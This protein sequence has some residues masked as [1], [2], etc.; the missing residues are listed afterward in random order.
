MRVLMLGWEFPP[1]IVGG[2]GTA[3]HGLTRGMNDI[4]TEVL[5]FLP[6]PVESSFSSHVTLLTPKGQL[7]MGSALYRMEEFE[8]VT[9]RVIDAG[10][11]IWAYQTPAQYAQ[12]L[13]G[14]KIEARERVALEGAGVQ[15]LLESPQTFMTS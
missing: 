11:G 15:L 10:L 5:F 1:F 7:A 13:A 12:Q 9:F 14:G 6:K 3:C 4:G 8:N 2:L